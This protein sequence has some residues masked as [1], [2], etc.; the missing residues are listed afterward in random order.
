[1]CSVCYSNVGGALS[2]CPTCT[3]RLGRIRSRVLERLRDKKMQRRNAAWQERGA[4]S[5]QGAE[6]EGETANAAPRAQSKVADVSA[7]ERAA[8]VQMQERAANRPGADAALQVHLTVQSNIAAVAAAV[9]AAAA[10]GDT[11]SSEEEDP[12]EARSEVRELCSEELAELVRSSRHTRV[13]L[14]VMFYTVTSKD[15]RRF[16]HVWNELHRR[17]A[18]NRSVFIAMFNCDA[19]QARALRTYRL[20]RFPTLQW[21]RPGAGHGQELQAGLRAHLESLLQWVH[22]CTREEER[23]CEEQ[24][25]PLAPPPLALPPNVPRLKLGPLGPAIDARD[26][27]PCWSERPPCSSERARLSSMSRRAQLRAHASRHA[28]PDV[29][30]AI[31]KARLG[32]RSALA[33]LLASDPSLLVRAQDPAGPSSLCAP[34]SGDGWACG[35]MVDL[36]GECRCG[37]ECVVVGGMKLHL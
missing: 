21:Y 23:E 10:A 31:L 28:D 34:G 1:L 11:A 18:S 32:K 33:A 9:A 15:C 37:R 7:H 30:A 17:L 19:D 29:R 12:A 6:P 27:P 8:D 13:H 26:R 3:T 16:M 25:P 14:F 22:A 20:K 4:G 36:L 5:H 35:W 2:P 24:V